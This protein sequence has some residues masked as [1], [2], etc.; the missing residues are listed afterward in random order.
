[1]LNHLKMLNEFYLL[2][3]LCDIFKHFD[4]FGQIIFRFVNV[5]EQGVALQ[6]FAIF[7]GTMKIIFHFIGHSNL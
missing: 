1:M 7:Y 3:S 4:G 5:G 6:L 2:C